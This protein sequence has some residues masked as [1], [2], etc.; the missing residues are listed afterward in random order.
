MSDVGV[1]PVV[2][3]C[4]AQ[5]NNSSSDHRSQPPRV[6]LREFGL[7]TSTHGV[8][9][10]TRSQT[11][12]NRLYWI[13]STLIFTGIMIYFITE[14]IRAYFDYPTL[15]LVTIKEESI[16]PFAAVSFC[17][18]SPLRYDRFIAPFLNYTNQ[19]NLTNTTDTTTFTAKQASY[20][21]DFFQYKLNNNES[22]TDYFYSLDSMLISCRFNG[23]NCSSKDFVSFVTSSFGYCYTFN[24]QTK[25][26]RNGTLYK[27][28]DNGRL[29]V[30][31]LELYVHSHQYVPYFTNG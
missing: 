24:A 9:G 31:E 11:L 7:N 2:K 29:G 18:Y 20:I 19:L 17:N 13:L 12:S 4:S 5:A 27:N 30:L 16:Q 26:I 8:P 10:I 23:L 28:T 14:T 6:I 1:I 15:T 3:I 25:N 21:R 22:L